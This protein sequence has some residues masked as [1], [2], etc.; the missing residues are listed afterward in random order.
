MNQ[1]RRTILASVTGLLM[2]LFCLPWLTL[3][4]IPDDLLIGALNRQLSDSG[5][6]IRAERLTRL[7]PMGIGATKLL[8]ADQN[9][10]WLKL[11]QANIR[12]QLLPLA[13]G[14]LGISLHATLNSARIEGKSSIW[15]AI[16][17]SFQAQG[18]ELADLG[19]VSNLLGCG[20]LKG[21]AK[22]DL[23]LQQKTKAAPQGTLKLQVQQV[24]L[25]QARISGL[26]LPGISCPELRGLLRLQGTTLTID[27]L[28]LQGDGIYLRLGGT[29]PLSAVA[30]LK[31]A[32]E[33][34]PTAEFLDKQKSLFLIM[35]PYQI[36]PGNYK[37][38][39]GGSL[40][41]PQL[42]SR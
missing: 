32:L 8:L 11:D 13:T 22:L 21:R 24:E 27:N 17:G 25:H 28:A 7:F 9:K 10:D 1:R 16:N 38:P 3:C 39:I 6:N 26:Q 36:S 40:A 19:V 4:F 12:L 5:L 31:L 35:L 20:S 18:L 14:K 34:M 30:P 2:A 29:A 15:P 42:I 33:L 23:T 37:L 41:A